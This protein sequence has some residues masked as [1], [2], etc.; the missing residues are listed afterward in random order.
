MLSVLEI[1][2]V[3]MVFISFDRINDSEGGG[4]VGSRPLVAMVCYGEREREEGQEGEYD[5]KYSKKS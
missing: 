4:V 2:G 3:Q 1:H 5:S